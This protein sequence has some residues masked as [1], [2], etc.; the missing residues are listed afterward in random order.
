MYNR[1][2]LSLELQHAYLG[3]EDSVASSIWPN[4]SKFGKQVS[5]F[6]VQQFYPIG[7]VAIGLDD[8]K[9]NVHQMHVSKKK[10]HSIPY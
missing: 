5:S 2:K 4:I 1:S 9:T 6:F 8:L 10:I 3:L 7:C